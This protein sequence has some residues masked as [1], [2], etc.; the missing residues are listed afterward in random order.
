MAQAVKKNKADEAR[1]QGNI[2]DI[3]NYRRC[4]FFAA[5]HRIAVKINKRPSEAEYNKHRKS[6]Y[7]TVTELKE[8]ADGKVLNGEWSDVLRKTRL[9]NYSKGI[10]AFEMLKIMNSYHKQA[11]NP[12]SG[13][14]KKEASNNDAYPSHSTIY[15]TVSN[16]NQFLYSLGYSLNRGSPVIEDLKE[17]REEYK[18][19]LQRYYGDVGTNSHDL[20]KNDKKSPGEACWHKIVDRLGDGS[21]DIALKRAGVFTKRDVKHHGSHNYGPNWDNKIRPKAIER[22]DYKC[23]MCPTTNEE[24]IRDYNSGLHAHH[25]VPF[26]WFDSKEKANQQFNL[27]PLCCSCHGELGQ[28]NGEIPVEKQLKNG[29]LGIS[30]QRSEKILEL[31]DEVTQ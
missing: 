15:P 21:F 27:I 13:G 30:K 23:Q 3:D 2:P 17:E 31:R 1:K 14:Y 7:P 25:I 6:N 24:H 28:G 9:S 16:W 26:D 29:Y 8:W 20:Y 5:V 18:E 11:D 22:H 12:T 10:D 4:D 19:L